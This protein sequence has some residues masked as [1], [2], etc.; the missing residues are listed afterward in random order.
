MKINKHNP[1]RLIGRTIMDHHSQWWFVKGVE[2]HHIILQKRSTI[3]K[4][5]IEMLSRC[6]LYPTHEEV[7]QHY[8][9][10]VRALRWAALLTHSEATGAVVG[11]I[12]NGPF[13][14][15]SEAVS[16]IGGSAQAIRQA[17]RCRHVTRE[18]YKRERLMKVA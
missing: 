1:E 4:L 14:C 18:L 6:R 17:W 8:P 12:V 9:L 15:G 3:G 7:E 13:S 2:D 5:N 11:H 10:L 16:H